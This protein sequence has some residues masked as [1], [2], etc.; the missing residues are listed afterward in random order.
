MKKLLLT[1][2]GSVVY[3]KNSEDRDYKES[4][5]FLN[6]IDS[7]SIDGKTAAIETVEINDLISFL[8]FKHGNTL[9]KWIIDEETNGAF[10][11]GVESIIPDAPDYK[12]LV[13]HINNDLHLGDFFLVDIV[14]V[15]G[16]DILTHDHILPEGAFSSDVEV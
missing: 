6:R 8:G 3:I 10:N 2:P 12:I 16:E 7:I 15:N 11:L 14:N 9:I 1:G 4:H 13:L 5:L